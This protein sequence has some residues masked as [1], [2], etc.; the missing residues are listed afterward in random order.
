MGSHCSVAFLAS[1]GGSLANLTRKN[2]A[3]ETRTA[4]ERSTTNSSCPE[5]HCSSLRLKL[6]REIDD[7]SDGSL[8]KASM[9]FGGD[10]WT[11]K[12]SCELIPLMCQ[13]P[14]SL[15]KDTAR[16]SR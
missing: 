4:A 10:F 12:F 11:E 13:L 14:K 15:Q 5:Y 7:S 2:L 16:L 6:E 1:V 9:L 3:G 8:T